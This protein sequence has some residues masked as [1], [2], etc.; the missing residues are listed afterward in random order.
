MAYPQEPF[1]LASS[2]QY[3]KIR[4]YAHDEQIYFSFKKSLAEVATQTLNPD[5]QSLVEFAKHN[6]LKINSTKSSVEVLGSVNTMWCLAGSIRI[7]IGNDTIPVIEFCDNLGVKI[8]SALCFRERDDCCNRKAF[9]A[10]K[11]LYNCRSLVN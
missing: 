8:D 11:L 10:S 7:V 4:N 2:L 3:A 9:G 6:S 5:L 1:K